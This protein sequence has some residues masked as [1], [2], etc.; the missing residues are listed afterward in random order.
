M[1][2]DS[3]MTPSSLHKRGLWLAGVRLVAVSVMVATSLAVRDE[4]FDHFSTYLRYIPWGFAS[5]FPFIVMAVAVLVAVDIACCGLWTWAS[6]RIGV[7]VRGSRTYGWLNWLIILMSVV[8]ILCPVGTFMPPYVGQVGDPQWLHTIPDPVRI[9][10]FCLAGPPALFIMIVLSCPALGLAW[11]S[12]DVAVVP[13]GKCWWCCY[14]CEA[15]TC[16][17]CGHGRVS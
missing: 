15:Q 11:A 14:E 12:R 8:T 7:W 17:E 9:A 6:R 3:A 10:A 4:P 5:G 16:P 2:S 1:G 13:R